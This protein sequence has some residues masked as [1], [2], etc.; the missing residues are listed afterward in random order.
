MRYVTRVRKDGEARSKRL[1]SN[2]IRDLWRWA[3]AYARRCKNAGAKRV[4]F[5]I[6]DTAVDNR[7]KYA[8]VHM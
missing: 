7:T 2:N 3:Y 6:W 1:E 5:R 8:R 4:T